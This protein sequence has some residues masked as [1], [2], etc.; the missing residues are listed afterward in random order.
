[1][2]YTVL[3]HN[4]GSEILPNLTENCLQNMH[5]CT[6]NKKI[7]IHSGG[8]KLFGKMCGWRMKLLLH[9]NT[10]YYK[11]IIYKFINKVLISTI[12]KLTWN[13]LEQEEVIQRMNKNHV[14]AKWTEYSY[15]DHLKI[16][17]KIAMFK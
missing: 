1:M 7:L 8:I 15:S 13:K 17:K 16:E 3:K 4:N 5:T 2:F 11:I 10:S 14:V 6:S 12:K 9:D